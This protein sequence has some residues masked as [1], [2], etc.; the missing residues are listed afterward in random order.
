MRGT[1]YLSLMHAVYK[2][3]NSFASLPILTTNVIRALFL[4]L[5]EDSLVFLAGIVAR[6]YEVKEDKAMCVAALRH[7]A[8]FLAAQP[9]VDFQ[10]I[11]PSLIVAISGADCSI[12][13]T[14]VDC[15][16]TMARDDNDLNAVYG[17][18]TV[19]GEHSG[20]YRHFI[21]SLLYFIDPRLLRQATC[22]IWILQTF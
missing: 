20:T 19:Y 14:A 3:A 18:D 15:I 9:S 4:K 21:S 11:L 12:R 16:T 1:R 22:N 7:A 2:F 13:A 8:S 17:F 6:S 5:Q 10:T